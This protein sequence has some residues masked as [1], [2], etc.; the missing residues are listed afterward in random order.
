[1]FLCFYVIN[2]QKQKNNQLILLQHIGT[3]VLIGEHRFI[4][5][6]HVNLCSSASMWYSKTER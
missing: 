5:K 6:N 3:I 2:T 1:M 4:L